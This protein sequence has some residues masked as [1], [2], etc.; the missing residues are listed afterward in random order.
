MCA[1]SNITFDDIY[2][3]DFHF[4]GRV[5]I[6]NNKFFIDERNN[7][8]GS[9]KD[10]ERLSA[11]FDELNYDVI[12][13]IDKTAEHMRKSI[14]EMVNY[15][16]KNVG[17]LLVFIM[18]HGVDGKILASDEQEIYLTDFINPFKNVQSLKNKPK[19][20]FVNACRG[21]GYVPIHDRVASDN[22]TS[23]DLH[24]AENTPIEADFLF[25]YSTVANYVSLRDSTNG[26][27]FMQILCDMIEQYKSTL[28]LSRILNRVNNGVAGK[29]G[30][31]QN[32]LLAK[33]MPTSTSQLK[34][35]FYFSA[36]NYVIFHFII[37]KLSIF[38]RVLTR[39]KSKNPL[40]APF[41]KFCKK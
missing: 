23:R 36:P 40:L 38:L 11:L 24:K 34:K 6:F 4:R 7:R 14:R 8:D 9:E 2:S 12:S 3:Q 17:S 10:V 35:D 31:D 39:V 37:V 25:A 26:S 5:C 13:Y 27:W 30:R 19:L 29:E 1:A 16:Y 21:E 32:N 33:M 20:F 22:Q 41:L 18:S 28:D 15:D